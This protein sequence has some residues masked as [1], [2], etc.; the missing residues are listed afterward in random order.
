MTTRPP[1][2]RAFPGD[3]EMHRL[4]REFD[5]S[6]NLL[7]PVDEWP[8]QLTTLVN[9]VLDSNHPMFIWWGPDLIQFYND[10]YRTTMGPERHP[11]ALGQPGRECWQEIWP[12]IGPQ[13]D[14]I[15]AGG[16]STWH[17]DQLVPVTRHGQR[18]DV[19]WTYGYS[20]VQDAS[21]IHGVLVVCNDVT[22]EHLAKQKLQAAI[23]ELNSE[24]RLRRH[25][26]ERLRVLFKQ[27]PGFM[28]ILQGPEHVFAFVNDTYLRLVG[29]RDLLGKPVQEALPEAV[30]QGFIALLDK[31][32]TTGQPHRAT[33]VPLAVQRRPGAP[34]TQLF[35]DFVYQPLIEADGSVSGIF[36]EGV[37]V[38]DL[39]NAQHG[40]KEAS[41][42]KDEFLAMLAHELRNPLA[43]ISSAAQMLVMGYQDAARVH[44]AG[45]IIMRQVGHL[46]AL[47]DDLLDVSR[48]TRGL[49]AI[50]SEPL[51]FNDVVGDALE[52]LEPAIQAHTH[53][54]KVNL[55]PLPAIVQ[56]DAKRLVQVVSNLLSNAF[57]FT[58]KGGSIGLSVDRQ[59]DSVLLTIS[60]DGIG[61]T[62]ETVGRVFDL[63]AQATL[64]IDR[65]T[66]G[67]GIGLALVKT[68]VELHGGT[69]TA[70][71]EGLALGSTFNV[72]LPAL[73]GVGDA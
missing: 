25:E 59:G 29:D 39:L 33:G 69:V 30:E 14:S 12:I 1:R 4:T 19:W 43:P 9:V 65:S 73:S 23:S 3:T 16:P 46:T 26:A 58:P 18:S 27:A 63:F 7:G 57:K 54:V 36:V 53:E 6:A 61:M 24:V 31:V 10:A 21:G 55:A 38:T 48:V 47:V 35:L 72:R 5:W 17:E 70:H 28:C 2:A 11:S 41:Q 49:V 37:D 64:G 50:T 66:G 8:T 62:P 60:D 20:P 45:N 22:Q 34:L 15:M 52:Q 44:R 40:L 56:G 42:R 32:F 51:N 13:I 68:L 67:L 71:S